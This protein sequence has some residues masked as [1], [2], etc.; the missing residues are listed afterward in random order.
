MEIIEA[1]QDA[2]RREVSLEDFVQ[3]GSECAVSFRRCA[4]QCGWIDSRE[5]A[6]ARKAL[7][8]EE[9]FGLSRTSMHP[10]LRRPS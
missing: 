3:S 8:V 7:D 1:S 4:A 10:G 9:L 2:T 6:K 5:D